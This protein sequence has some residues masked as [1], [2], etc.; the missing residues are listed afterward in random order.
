MD[1]PSTFLTSTFNTAEVIVVAAGVVVVVVD[2][3]VVDVVVVPIIAW[4][5]CICAFTAA[6]VNNVAAAPVFLTSALKGCS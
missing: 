2:I 6:S 3:D 5:T 1:A 4:K